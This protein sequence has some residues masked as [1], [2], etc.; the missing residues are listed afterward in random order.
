[1]SDKIIFMK[2]KIAFIL[3][4]F[5][6]ANL[7]GDG[8]AMSEIMDILKEKYEITVIT[9]KALDFSYW[10]NPFSKNKIDKEFEEKSG[11][12][13]Y[14]L[15]CNQT[16][17]LFLYFIREIS[18]Y[19]ILNFLIPKKILNKSNTFIG[20]IF[21][22][23]DNILDKEKF[24]HIHFCPAPYLFP[25]ELLDLIKK[26]FPITKTSITPFFHSENN[27]YY[28]ELYK[29]FYNQV[30]LIHVVTE[31]EKNLLIE[32]LQIKTDKIKVIPLFISQN[33]I[34]VTEKEINDFKERYDLNNKTIILFVGPKDN[35]KGFDDLVEATE[36]IY[37]E[38][39]NIKLITLGQPELRQI[40]NYYPDMENFILDLGFITDNKEK[41]IIF[42][43]S[44]IYA[45]TSKYESFGLVYLEA[46]DSKL[47]VIAGDIPAVKE[48]IGDAGVIVELNNTLEL[49]K[50]LSK[51]INNDEYRVKLG[52]SGYDRYTKFFIKTLT[53]E[54]YEKFFE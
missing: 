39:K 9:T 49:Q 29:N 2:K 34:N 52:Q 51:L 18:K 10:I 19:K 48:L 43:S 16:Y 40:K 37:Q 41:K 33:E 42:S 50:E 53:K 36:R 28:T 15:N 3:P 4:L 21:T 17:S 30:D 8:I 35:L 27:L 31:F 26:N 45:M 11:I 38:N 24:N 5:K 6:P 32:G 22:G 7:R 44:H 20:P 13:V 23:I 46:W 25:I 1:M 12:K 47:P 54:K 14:R